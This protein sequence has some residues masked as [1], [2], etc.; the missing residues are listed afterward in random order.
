M[1]QEPEKQIE[2]LKKQLDEADA[3]II[4]AGSG[5]STAAGYRYTG[6][7]FRKY[8]SDFA[9]KYGIRDMYSGGFSPFGSMEE[10]WGYWCRYVWINRYAPIPTDLYAKL[11][12]LVKDRDHFVLTT[13]VDH[14][15][16]RSGFDKS[17]LFYTQGDY[18]LFQSSSGA[19]SK[20]TYDNHDMIRRMVLSEGYSIDGSG[21]LIVPENGKVSMTIPEGLVPVCP[22]DGKPMTM[23]LRSDDTFVEDEGW[24]EAEERYQRFLDGHADGHVLYLELGVGMNT[25]VIIKFPFWKS[26]M[27]NPDAFYACV[28]MGEACCP[29]EINDRSLCIDGDIGDVLRRL[30]Q[31]L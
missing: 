27:V 2:I 6:D 31:N 17:R 1:T 4:G 5:L 7:R 13:N 21:E 30:M 16:Q 15:F 26:T 14:C 3:V 28:N 12:E 8:F 23:N 9:E 11:H 25:P 24:H 20:K 29:E 10:Y 18:G 22:D 19:S